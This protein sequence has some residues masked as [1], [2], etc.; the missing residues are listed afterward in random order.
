MK[1]GRGRGGGKHRKFFPFSFFTKTISR[2]KTESNSLLGP[3]V[4]PFPS[5]VLGRKSEGR[6]EGVDGKGGRYIPIGVVVQRLQYSLYGERLLL[7]PSGCGLI[8]I[9]ER[10]SGFANSGFTTHWTPDP[11]I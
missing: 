9:L 11:V 7:F 8:N 3:T 5:T 1:S 4:H 6:E 10:R 2:V